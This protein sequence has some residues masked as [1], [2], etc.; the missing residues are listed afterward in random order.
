MEMKTLKV[1]GPNTM[2]CRGCETTVKFALW[3]LPGMHQIDANY[4]TQIIQLTFDPQ[5]VGFEQVRQVLDW[6]GYQVE[7]ATNI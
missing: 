7:E 2:H 1:V 6:L 5:S 3:Q 4:Q